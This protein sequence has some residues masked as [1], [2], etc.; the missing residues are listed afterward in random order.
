VAIAVPHN[1][2]RLA[3]Q[4]PQWTL[5]APR[6]NGFFRAVINRL[7]TDVTVTLHA[8]NVRKLRLLS[9]ADGAPTLQL[10]W[11]ALLLVPLRHSHVPAS[12]QARTYQM[13]T[14]VL[15]FIKA[16]LLITSASR[17]LTARVVRDQTISASGAI[18]GTHHCACLEAWHQSPAS[19]V[20]TPMSY[21]TGRYALQR[22]S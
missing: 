5:I 15:G 1:D 18:R 9:P 21:H 12:L 14:L 16:A 3:A 8:T 19:S 2:V 20:L 22:Q 13:W 10:V 17:R 4:L 11:G 7:S 6:N